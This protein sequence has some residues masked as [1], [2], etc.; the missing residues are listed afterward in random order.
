MYRL[1][2]GIAVAAHVIGATMIGAQVGAAQ[3]SP[4]QPARATDRQEALGHGAPD[5]TGTWVLSKTKSDFGLLPIPVGD[6]AIYTRAGST[7]HVVETAGTDTGAAHIAYSWPVGAGDVSSE[8]P[9]EEASI[10]TRVT[11]HSD[12]ALFVSQLRHKG[13]AIEIQSGREYLSPDGKVRTR[14]FDLQSLTN[15][16]EDVQHILAV[17]DRTG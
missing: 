9:D 13:Q 3:A 10:S 4:S 8:L 1:P 7:Y 5:L 14:E 12:T 2:S 6:T 11:L 17:F 16:D 15:P